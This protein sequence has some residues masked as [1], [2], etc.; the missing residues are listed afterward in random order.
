MLHHFNTL[1]I[2]EITQHSVK[3]NNTIDLE[4]LSDQGKVDINSDQ[5]STRR[6]VCDWLHY[7]PAVLTPCQLCKKAKLQ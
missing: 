7:I 4:Y 1:Y 6:E 2:K 3:N 5:C